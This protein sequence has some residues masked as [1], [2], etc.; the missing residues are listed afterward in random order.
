MELYGGRR[1]ENHSYWR[2]LCNRAGVSVSGVI[3]FVNVWGLGLSLDRVPKRTLVDG[4]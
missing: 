4:L 3:P 2:G 1:Q